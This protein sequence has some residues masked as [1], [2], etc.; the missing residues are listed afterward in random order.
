MRRAPRARSAL[1]AGDRARVDKSRVCRPLLTATM[2]LDLDSLE[3][4]R[5]FELIKIAKHYEVVEQRG[6]TSTTPPW[7]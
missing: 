5:V 6:R 4:D 3:F 7:R 2:R 1:R